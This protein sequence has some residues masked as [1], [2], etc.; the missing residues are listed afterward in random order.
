MLLSDGS[1]QVSTTCPS[2]G[3][4]LSPVGCAGL[5]LGSPNVDDAT[6]NT[7]PA[8]ARTSNQYRVPLVSPV[9]VYPVVAAPLI[10]MSVQFPQLMLFDG[11]VP[12]RYWYFV[13]ALLLG[14]LHARV[15]WVSPSVMVRPGASGA[16]AGRG[17]A[18]SV[19]D[20]APFPDKP[21]A[22]SRKAYLV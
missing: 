5:G 9:T 3:A 20:R 4:A 19:V 12:R 8:T 11:P 16:P 7:V 14:S 21:T 15:T 6:P 17:I 13:M 1:L 10:G 2:P 18:L 22:R